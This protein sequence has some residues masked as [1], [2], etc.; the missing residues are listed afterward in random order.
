MAELIVS[1]IFTGIVSGLL[2]VLVALGLTIIFGFMNV[3]NF[4]HG[5]FY[6][7]GAYVGLVVWRA[8]ES[9]WLGLLVVPLALALIGFVVERFL[10]RP[11]Y[12][13]NI[14]DPLLLTFGMTFVL[15]EIVRIIFGSIGISLSVPEALSGTLTFGRFIFP[16]YFLFIA[17][18]A[19]L[20][21]VVLWLF[22]E[23]T[24]VGLII[25]AGTQDSV[26]VGALGIDVTRYR[27]LVFALG[28]ALAGIAGL[29]SAPRTGLTPDMGTAILIFAFVVVV[30]GGLGSYWGA[31]VSGIL[32]GVVISLT[33]LF[34][35]QLAQI[36][37]F[38]FMALVLLIR[39]RGLFGAAAHS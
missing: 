7:V 29:L 11:M 32:T 21:V 37:V 38:V 6:M 28:I 18:V 10:I 24:D 20:L 36:V 23:K 5:A 34:Y 8:T 17:A 33:A 3:V 25:R 12:A 27:T 9:F 4:A 19:I 26:M 1:Q 39:P 16:A 31:V 22:L 35:P 14:F 30:I 15:I 2:L 13:R